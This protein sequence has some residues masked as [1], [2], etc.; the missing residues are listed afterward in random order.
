MFRRKFKGFNYVL[1][2]LEVV[3]VSLIIGLFVLLI[4]QFV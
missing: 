1:V 4:D 2:A 3:I